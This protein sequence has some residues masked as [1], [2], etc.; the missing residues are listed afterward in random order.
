MIENS[1]A[2]LVYFNCRGTGHYYRYLLYEIG[3]A[4]QEIHVNLDG[5]MPECLKNYA[6]TLADIPCII[7]EGKVFKELYPSI[8]YLCS[9]FD[10]SDLLGN[11][12]YEQVLRTLR[13]PKLARCSAR[14]PRRGAT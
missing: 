9:K 5:T 3:C 1:I 10:R 8:R 6:I 4:F 2:Y 7:V 14:A 11:N 13:R 12:L